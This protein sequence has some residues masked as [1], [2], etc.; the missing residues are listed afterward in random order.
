MNWAIIVHGGA[1]A[2]PDDEIE[3]HENGCLRAAE[4]G[5]AVLEKGGS[6]LDAVEVATRILEDDPTFNAGYGSALNSDGEVEMDAAIMEG[7]ELRAGAVASIRAVRHPISVARRVMETEHVLLSGEGAQRFA[8]ARE[9]ELCEPEDMV[10]DAQRQKWESSRKTRGSDT[11]GAVA[12]DMSGTFAAATSTGGL[13]HKMPGRIG[14]SPLVGLGLYADNSAGGCS[15][16]GDGESIIRMALAHRVIQSMQNGVDADR[17]AE[18]AIAAMARRVGGEAGCIVIDRHGEVGHA[19][20][21]PNLPI[22]WRTS[23]MGAASAS[24]KKER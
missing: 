11:V 16:T 9:L 4:A 19:H 12:R 23:A 24:V 2:V 1:H 22:A 8:G 6:A 15:M 17:A 20:N 14:D 13:M 18:E 10:Y 5:A 3:A 7:A 21:A